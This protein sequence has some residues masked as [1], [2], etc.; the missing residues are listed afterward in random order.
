MPHAPSLAAQSMLAFQK[1]MQTTTPQVS[2]ASLLDELALCLVQL[3]FQLS[4]ALRDRSYHNAPFTPLFQQ[5]LL[6]GLYSMVPCT[7]VVP[8]CP[9]N[10]PCC[11][12]WCGSTDG[13]TDRSFSVDKVPAASGILTLSSRLDMRQNN[14]KIPIIHYSLPYT[15]KPTC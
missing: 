7:L 2:P 5:T 6:S 10:S 14:G 3:K 9:P 13:S 1:L 11:K 15:T 12:M 8:T 4:Q